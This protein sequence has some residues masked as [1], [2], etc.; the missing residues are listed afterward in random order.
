MAELVF[1]ALETDLARHP[2][3]GS[4]AG[5]NGGPCRRKR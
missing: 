4:E 2:I 5:P 1:L 3:S